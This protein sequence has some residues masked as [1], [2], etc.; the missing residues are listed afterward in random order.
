MPTTVLED[1]VR[2]GV[3]TRRTRAINFGA[4]P[5]SD[6][7]LLEGSLRLDTTTSSALKRQ[8]SGAGTM[9]NGRFVILPLQGQ[10]EFSDEGQ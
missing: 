6:R 9:R 4:Q 7:R 2:S 1:H 10:I 3:E 8:S 5:L